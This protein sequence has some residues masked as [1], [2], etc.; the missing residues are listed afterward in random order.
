MHIVIKKLYNIPIFLD[1][2]GRLL[3][4]TVGDYMV[5]DFNKLEDYDFYLTDINVI[6]QKPIYRVLDVKSR[7]YNG[8]IYIKKG[9]C[10]WEWE[11]SECNLSQGGLVYLPKGSRHLF[12]IL[13]DD[14]ELYRVDFNLHINGEIALF[15]ER[16]LKITDILSSESVEYLNLLYTGLEAQNNS[17]FK[18]EKLCGFLRTVQ[19]KTVSSN[20]K[21]L[22]P[23]TN[24]INEH[25]DE[26][27]DF[28]YIATL[29]YM[30]TS[31]FY[32]LFKKEYGIT[33]L[34]YKNNLVLNRAIN[35]LKYGDISVKEIALVLGFL[36]DGYFCR[37]FKKHTGK[38][39]REYKFKA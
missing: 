12:K 20:T 38:T 15:S 23:A 9:E 32:A 19:T 39:P 29:C 1:L 31:Q 14:I 8:F 18:T 33:P 22:M 25:F 13:S 6:I 11:D 3:Y 34:E 35:M 10:S 27:I 36:S 16:P 7:L 21:K 17:I 4:N 26:D 24:Y 2:K 28:K 37:F 5:I 30:S